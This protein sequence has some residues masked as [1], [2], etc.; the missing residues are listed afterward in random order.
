[1]EL[2]AHDKTSFNLTK[3]YATEVV[4][5]RCEQ[6]RDPTAGSGGGSSTDLVKV[7][8]ATVRNDGDHR[9]HTLVGSG[10]GC[11]VIKVPFATVTFIIVGI[12]MEVDLRSATINEE[13]KEKTGPGSISIPFASL[14]TDLESTALTFLYSIV[15]QGPDVPPYVVEGPPV[16]RVI[17]TSDPHV[18]E[19]T[20]PPHKHSLAVAKDGCNSKVCVKAVRVSIPV[21]SAEVILRRTLEYLTEYVTSVPYLESLYGVGSTV[22]SEVHPEI[23]C[24]DRTK[25]HTK[26]VETTIQ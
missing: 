18:S 24:N 23:P 10:K 9:D 26:T 1:M 15:H 22:T 11:F 19:V 2:A 14:T 6:K 17:F 21:G 16:N 13:V 20:C 3:L 4:L 8:V 7:T 25:C 5:A 12:G